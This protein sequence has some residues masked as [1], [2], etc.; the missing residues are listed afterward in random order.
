MKSR[1]H[2]TW[3]E[4]YWG[5]PLPL[6]SIVSL[7]WNTRI[8]LTWE[9]WRLFYTIIVNSKLIGS[10]LFSNGLQWTLAELSASISSGNTHPHKPIR[11]SKTMRYRSQKNW[12]KNSFLKLFQLHFFFSCDS[13]Q[14]GFLHQNYL[15]THHKRHHATKQSEHE[16]SK[17]QTTS[18]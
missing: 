10:N 14:K 2:L 13:C 11:N 8:M 6:L 4:C 12:H 7:V 5:F 15:Y 17:S 18:E 9:I 16:L 3:A 1:Y